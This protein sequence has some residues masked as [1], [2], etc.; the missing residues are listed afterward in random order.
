MAK[1]DEFELEVESLKEHFVMLIGYALK[2]MPGKPGPERF[3]AVM[4]AA[5]S[6]LI[7]AAMARSCPK[8]DGGSEY[9]LVSGSLQR[10]LLDAV[11]DW[12][13]WRGE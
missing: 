5:I 1:L 9:S 7:G 6:L 10:R 3:E 13:R 12:D 8:V 11:E 2:R 4:R